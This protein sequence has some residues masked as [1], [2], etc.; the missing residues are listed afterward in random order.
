MTAGLNPVAIVTGASS[1]IGLAT[2]QQLAAKGWRIALVA[3]DPG[4][5]DHALATLQQPDNA[6]HLTIPC[7]LAGPGAADRFVQAALAHFARIDALVN[8][9]GIAPLAPI[10]QHDESTLQR[11]FAINA[12]APARAIAACWPQFCRQRRAVI[13]NV[14]TLGTR[15]PF[16]GFFGYAA[17]KAAVNLLARS[18][19]NEGAPHN[20]RAFSVAPGAVETPM[21]RALFD[22]ATLPTSA[23]LSPDAVATV[24]LDCV[25]GR[26]DHENGHTIFLSP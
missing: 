9:A 10:D 23:C 1:G 13:V 12:I 19:A 24:I 21:L 3:R 22:T 17:S 18:A 2:A 26:R 6:H 20:I 14:S 7:D 11:T 8:N 16:P 15:D 25:E 4:R 5:L